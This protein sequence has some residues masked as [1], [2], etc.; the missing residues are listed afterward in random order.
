[1]TFSDSKLDE[2]L[3]F[4]HQHTAK[5]TYKDIIEEQLKAAL[6]TLESEPADKLKEVYYLTLSIAAYQFANETQDLPM[7]IDPFKWQL[8]MNQGSIRR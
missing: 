2:I 3:N 1:M 5:I 4:F 7:P 6:E 8:V